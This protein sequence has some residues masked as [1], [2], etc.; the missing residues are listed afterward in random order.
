MQPP[1]SLWLNQRHFR[2]SLVPHPRIVY[3]PPPGDRLRGVKAVSEGER[4]A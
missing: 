2:H 1:N 3:T 4:A